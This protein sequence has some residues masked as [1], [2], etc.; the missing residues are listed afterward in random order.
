MR[1]A[2]VVFFTTVLTEGASTQGLREPGRVPL[3]GGLAITAAVAHP[4]GDAEVIFLVQSVAPEVR[5][6]PGT[7]VGMM[8][9]SQQAGLLQLTDGGGRLMVEAGV[10]AKDGAGIVRTGPDMRHSGVGIVGLTPSSIRG[11]P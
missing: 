10:D 7:I 9:A 2:G 3:V 1:V 8:S 4:S 5:N 6:G 11:K